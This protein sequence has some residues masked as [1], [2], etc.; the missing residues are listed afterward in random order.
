MRAGRPEPPPSPQVLARSGMVWT[1]WLVASRGRT[2]A[3]SACPLSVCAPL[4]EDAGP[5]GPGLNCLLSLWQ[6]HFF[7]LCALCRWVGSSWGKGLRY[8]RGKRGSMEWCDPGRRSLRGWI[9]G[10]PWV[11]GRG[12]ALGSPGQL[13]ESSPWEKSSFSGP[14]CLGSEEW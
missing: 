14:R 2:G 6:V 5:T 10:S 1:E 13:G 4:V 3:L 8:P 9:R 7:G 12:K 11:W